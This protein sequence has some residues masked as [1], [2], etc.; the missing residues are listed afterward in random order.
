[1][2]LLANG[3][4]VLNFEM[5]PYG[6]LQASCW[7]HARYRL[8]LSLDISDQWTPDQE[9]LTESFSLVLLHFLKE[10]KEKVKLMPC[11]FFCVRQ[12]FTA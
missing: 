5:T 9:Y 4:T 7:L 11:V 6:D 3:G 8:G 12:H 1:M 2:L 10:T